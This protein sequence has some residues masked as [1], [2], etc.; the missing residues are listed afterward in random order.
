MAEA[1]CV[2]D[3][4]T[5]TV[6]GVWLDPELA[7]AQIEEFKAAKVV[8]DALPVAHSWDSSAVARLAK[9]R[10]AIEL[11]EEA[12]LVRWHGELERGQF[13]CVFAEGRFEIQVKE[14]RGFEGWR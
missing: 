8:L 4:E 1:Y 14:V 6:M 7:R 11:L 3:L 12:G 9:R 13:R 2:V 5:M 10:K